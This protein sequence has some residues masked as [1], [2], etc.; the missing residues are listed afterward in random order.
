MQALSPKTQC[1]STCPFGYAG[2]EV[3]SDINPAITHASS[4][5]VLVIWFGNGK[6]NW[7]QRNK[8]KSFAEH[9]KQ[10]TGKCVH[11]SVYM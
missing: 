9:R 4:G 6:F 1:C 2:W 8:L 11:A 5:K 10:F 7:E 3:H